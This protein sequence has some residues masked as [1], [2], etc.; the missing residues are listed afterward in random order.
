MTKKQLFWWVI[1]ILL[2][3]LPIAGGAY[4][5]YYFYYLPN[6]KTAET[7]NQNPPADEGPQ[8]KTFTGEFVTGET[9]QGWTIVEYKN[10]LGTTMLTSGVN[11]TGLT[12]LEVKNPTGEVVFAMHAVYGVGGVDIC[13]NYYKF[14]D[15][16]TTD[17]NSIT[18]YNAE[19]GEPAP[20]IVDLS[21]S[22]YSSIDLFDI[23]VRRIGTKLYWDTNPALTTFEASCGALE[24]FFA[25]GTP[26]FT[27]IETGNPPQTNG[28][29]HFV[30]LTTATTED[31]ATLD[32]ILSSLTVN[33]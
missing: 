24:N 14:A 19:A 29:Y 12:A 2:I 32:S 13:Q 25:F 17:F 33:P 10:G 26:R 7:E 22:T 31:L 28:G 1:L 4:A 30:V 6:Q 9:P 8:T 18:N 11:Y 3:A 15:N 5:F 16:S 20:T 27:I 21:T 23:K